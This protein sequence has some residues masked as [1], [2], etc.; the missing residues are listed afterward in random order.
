VFAVLTKF[1][2]AKDLTKDEIEGLLLLETLPPPP[3]SKKEAEKLK[4][5]KL[6]R[7]I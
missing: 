2:K 3:P 7:Q 4:W 6:L 1:S 5:E